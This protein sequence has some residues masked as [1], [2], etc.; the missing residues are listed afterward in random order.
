MDE[1]RKPFLSAAVVLISLAVIVELGFGAYVASHVGGA[2]AGLD[3]AT[4]GYGISYLGCIDVLLLYSLVLMTLSMVV[5]K[6]I[7]GR[8]QGIVGLIVSLLGLLALIVLIFFAIQLL[9][10]MISLLFAPIFGTLAYIAAFGTFSKGTAS[11]TLSFIMLL[12]IAFAICLIE[13]GR[14]SCRKECRSLW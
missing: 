1:L 12:K 6:E 11:A 13:I 3:R 8:L 4:P 14:A 2:A 10:L 9:I 5:S 7:T